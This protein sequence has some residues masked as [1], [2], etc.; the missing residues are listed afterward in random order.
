MSDLNK[1]LEI[2]DILDQ[3]GH[4]NHADFITLALKKEAKKGYHK[5]GLREETVNQHMTLLEGYRE[6]RDH[7]DEQYKKAIRKKG[8]DS[9][10]MG[11][12]REILR[13]C[14]HNCNAVFLHEM[15]MADVVDCRP[16]S[17]DKDST[18]R[19]LL[20]LYDGG[21]K[22]LVE[23]LKRIAKLPRN[24][25][26]L[27]NFCT[28]EKKLYLDIIDLHEIGPVVSSVPV[29]ALDMW[30]HAYYHDFGLDKDAYVEWF[31]S[32]MDWRNV[33]KRIKNLQRLK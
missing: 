26:V 5:C 16:Y 19:D 6:A 10:N 13:N 25:W 3:H 22:S 17:L 4:E 33:R 23:D 2:A 7:Y 18:T 11:A 29:M 30:E 14:A 9:P 31:L 20:K 1:Y 8:K 32:R 21:H 24:G 15:Y 27:L 28:L 12:L